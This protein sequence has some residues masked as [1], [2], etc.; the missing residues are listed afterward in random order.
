[1]DF[2]QIEAFAA[3][4][5]HGSFS[6]AAEA[7]YLT[8]PTVSAHVALLEQELG[9]KLLHRTTKAL[10]PTEAGQALYTYAR[11]LLDTREEACRVMSERYGD[12]SATITLAVSTVPSQ[13]YLPKLTAA[14]RDEHPGIAFEVLHGNSGN[15]EAML[16]SGKAELALIGKKPESTR[17]MAV[18]FA[19][20]TLVVIT[21]NIPR[22]RALLGRDFP[23]SMLLTE[24]FV[25]RELGSGTRAETEAFLRSVNIDPAALNTVVE[26]RS[27][28]GVKKMVSEGA[29]IAI[30][31]KAASD[32]YADFG[33]ILS[34]SPDSDPP[35]RKLYV[36]RLRNSSLSQ[37]ARSFFE[38]VRDSG[39]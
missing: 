18:P 31:S 16:L 36:L 2:K 38:F 37:A 13:N 23:L 1:M 34:F 35:R 9:V 39:K 27:T 19:E 33:K 6:R 8:Q 25:S 14:F 21:P 17:C 20:D 26:T 4:M 7:L 10:S 22:Y 5:E 11:Q 32:D 12:Q 15:A 24:P 30:V 28:E 29:G 3:V